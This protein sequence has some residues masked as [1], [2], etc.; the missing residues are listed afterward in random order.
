MTVPCP[1]D[2]R[3][4]RDRRRSAQQGNRRDQ[5]ERAHAESTVDSSAVEAL[6]LF[7]I[8]HEPWPDRYPWNWLRVNL[9]CS[10]LARAQRY[11]PTCPDQALNRD[12]RRS[13]LPA[14]CITVSSPAAVCQAPARL[15]RARRPTVPMQSC[16]GC[17]DTGR[18]P[19]AT[20]SRADSHL[21]FRV[22]PNSPS[23]RKRV[24]SVK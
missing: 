9:K 3:L 18:E 13:S 2:S 6:T 7:A 8:F 19:R 17:R 23:L 20:A 10:W 21:S 5:S 24:P 16:C 4:L 12:T 22:R 14:R 1:R 15:A 11:T